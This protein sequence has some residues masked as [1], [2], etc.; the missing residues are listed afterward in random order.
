MNETSTEIPGAAIEALKRGNKVEAIK[1]TREA[2][3]MGLKAS[4]EAVEARLREDA[5]L[6]EAY[7]VAKPAGS[8]L[9]L[10]AFVVVVTLLLYWFWSG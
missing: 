4:K 10:L 2:T 1:L 7:R 3:A 6:A 8:P 5:E 9:P